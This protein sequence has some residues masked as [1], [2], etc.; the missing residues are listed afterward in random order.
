MSTVTVTEVEVYEP[1]VLDEPKC[2]KWQE[3]TLWF[4]FIALLV[5]MLTVGFTVV[6]NL[7]LQTTT[8]STVYIPEYP[9]P[10]THY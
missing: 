9:L 3:S 5:V 10:G 8:T 4:V 1:I 7:H 2:A 6:S